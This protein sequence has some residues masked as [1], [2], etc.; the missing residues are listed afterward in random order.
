M[1]SLLFALALLLLETNYAQSGT[2]V[3]ETSQDQ[4]FYRNIRNTLKINTLL[5][6]EKYEVVL[7][8]CDSIIPILPK[9]EYS[10]IPGNG[11]M[12]IVELVDPTDLNR[13]LYTEMIKIEYLPNPELF[14]GGSINGSKISP[15]A[16]RIFAKYPPSYNLPDAQF[17][18]EIIRWTIMIGDLTFEGDGNAITEEVKQELVNCNTGFLSMLAVVKGPDGVLRKVGGVYNIH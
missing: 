5:P 2:F 13:V 12:V 8:N 4:F 10:F 1:R 14:Y 9:Q 15:S 7:R 3:L 16:G 6:T 18:F 17:P 11:R